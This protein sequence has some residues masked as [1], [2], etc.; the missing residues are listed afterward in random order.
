MWIAKNSIT[1]KTYGKAFKSIYDCQEYIDKDL[2]FLQYEWKSLSKMESLY[3][4]EECF[5]KWKSKNFKE[6]GNFVIDT[7]QS[8]MQY[9]IE[10]LSSMKS[11]DGSH[12][13]NVIR[14]YETSQKRYA[15]G[16]DF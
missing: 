9:L 3:D 1:G 10:Y 15:D 14:C 4:D 5:L 13:Q 12:G 8:R 11:F 6:T 7:F 16:F 2:L